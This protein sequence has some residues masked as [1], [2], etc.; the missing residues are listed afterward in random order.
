M[1]DRWHFEGFDE[2]Y[3]IWK[4]RDTPARNLREEVLDWFISL[5]TN[6]YRRATRLSEF[7]PDWWWARAAETPTHAVICQYQVDEGR[8]ALLVRNL[9]TLRKPI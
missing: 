6:Q 1:N 9:A 5:E 2:A 4:E 7:G 3:E 8:Q